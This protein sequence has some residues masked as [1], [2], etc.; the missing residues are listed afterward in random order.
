M[1]TY[2]Q[3][4]KSTLLDISTQDKLRT[5]NLE[6]QF[7]VKMTSLEYDFFKD[8][9]GS[10]I[11]YCTFLVDRKW[12]K[13]TQRRQKC[14]L[15]HERIKKNKERSRPEV[16]PWKEVPSDLHPGEST[17]TSEGD[18]EEL[19]YEGRDAVSDSDGDVP[20]PIKMQRISDVMET[21]SDKLPEEFRHMQQSIKQ[22]KPEFYT[23][24]DQLIS[25][26]HCFKH[27]FS[28]DN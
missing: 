17:A 28:S 27:G 5:R 23:I 14:Q 20:R 15:S 2:N 7:G 4:L 26:N 21:P 25:T 19:I 13:T 11:A 8:Q 22:V 3:Q 6:E 12:E 10:R 16:I 18:T 9:K 24:V 1:S